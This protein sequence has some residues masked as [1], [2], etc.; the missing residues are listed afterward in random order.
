MAKAID[1]SRTKTLRT[2]M[3]RAIHKRLNEFQ[4]R[5]VSLLVDMDAFGLTLNVGIDDVTAREFAF[6]TNARKVEEFT[7]I[8]SE[9]MGLIHDREVFEQFIEEGYEKGSKRAA[10]AVNKG[11]V[12]ASTSDTLREFLAGQ[13]AGFVSGFIQGPVAREKV[14]LLVSRTFSDLVGMTESLAGKLRRHLADGLAQGDNPRVIA[15]RMFQ[16]IGRTRKHAELIARTELVRVNAEGQLDSLEAMGLDKVQVQVEWSTAGDDR[17]CPICSPLEG[18]VFEIKKSHGL[19]PA[20]PNA[21]FETSSFQWYGKF[22]ELVRAWYDG[23]AV[24]IKCTGQG[25]DRNRRV[26]DT[27]IGPNHPIQTKRGMVKASEL[28]RSDSVLVD[29]SP[30][31]ESA[32]CVEDTFQVLLNKDHHDDIG[33]SESDLHGDISHCKGP[34]MSIKPSDKWLGN[35]IPDIDY[36]ISQCPSAVGAYR[37]AA[38]DSVRMTRFNGWAYDASTSCGLYNSDG[39]VVS[40]CRCSFIPANVGESS[41]GQKRSRAAKKQIARSNKA[42]GKRGPRISKGAVATKKAESIT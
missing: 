40:N 37:W 1:P 10:Q 13:E 11:Q 36:M 3:V 23:P 28:T 35:V 4:R 8:L 5:L 24:C 41:E 12:A 42:R 25:Y 6:E 18:V 30:K 31:L 7:A 9:E 21:I 27:V 19:I 16:D 26:Y 39:F 22:L 17:V 33:T 20:H 32:A 34:V 15:R 38:V 2:K 14:E 29:A